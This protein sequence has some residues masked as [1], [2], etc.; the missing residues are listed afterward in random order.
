MKHLLI[1]QAENGQ[2]LRVEV[3]DWLYTWIAENIGDPGIESMDD[4]GTTEKTKI[5]NVEVRKN[6]ICNR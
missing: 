2:R 5:L 1:M 6:E 3:P 4:F